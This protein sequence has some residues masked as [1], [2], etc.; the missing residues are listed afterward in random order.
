MSVNNKSYVIDGVSLNPKDYIY[1]KNRVL[2]KDPLNEIYWYILTE[3]KATINILF[4]N[5]SESFF[6]NHLKGDLYLI[7]YRLHNNDDWYI[8][9]IREEIVKEF[10]KKKCKNVYVTNVG[11]VIRAWHIFLYSEVTYEIMYKNSLIQLK[12]KDEELLQANNIIKDLKKRLKEFEKSKEGLQLYEN[13]NSKDCLKDLCLR[14]GK[15]IDS[16]RVD[17][18]RLVEEN[19]R[20]RNELLTLKSKTINF[21]KFFHKKNS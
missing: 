15:Q 12:Q 7:W 10:H 21:S 19:T 11:E 4:K 9:K 2:E 3:T 14:L 5:P 18:K 20:I 13:A 1:I 17:N 16:L 6:K 8:P